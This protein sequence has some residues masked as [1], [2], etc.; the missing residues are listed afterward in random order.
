MVYM[1]VEGRENYVENRK[2][3]QELLEIKKEVGARKWIIIG[4]LNAHI[5]IN[6]ERVNVNGQMLLDFEEE[7]QMRIMSWHCNWSI[8]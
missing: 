4:D 6:N 7:R 5:G 2:L 3:Y 1:G 8:Q